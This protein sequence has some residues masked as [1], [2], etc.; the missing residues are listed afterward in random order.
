M[1]PNKKKLFEYTV[2][3]LFML[4]GLAIAQLAFEGNSIDGVQVIAGKHSSTGKTAVPKVDANGNLLVASGSSLTG[5]CASVQ[6]TVAIVVDG[7]SGTTKDCGS[8]GTVRRAAIKN[9]SR[10][11]R[12]E[13]EDSTNT[14][15]IALLPGESYTNALDNAA[16]PDS[17]VV[18]TA[19]TRCGGGA[20][21]VSLEC[22]DDD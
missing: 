21:P 1:K 11:F 7:S 2:G 17:F 13:V 15:P 18:N 8:T 10:T 9:D 19:C 6:R 14:S 5:S 12:I 16:T 3:F 22:C 20:V 4:T